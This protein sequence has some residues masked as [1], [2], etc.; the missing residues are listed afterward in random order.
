MVIGTLTVLL[1]VSANAHVR[2]RPMDS[3]PGA[4]ESYQVT[5]PTEGKVSTIRTELVV[6]A[7]VV[8]IAVDGSKPHVM[9]KDSNGATVI[10]WED[11]I[12]PGNARQ[13]LF[14]ARNPKGSSEI[15]WKAHQ[16]FED[17]T[18]T[19]WMDAPGSR[20]PASVTKLQD[21]P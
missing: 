13:Y 11:T 17:G 20:R 6:P 10:V 12:P 2:V 14:T 16:Y 15:V 8:I 19:D 5:V 4:T 9:R 18:V 7:D 1:A 3:K 21:A